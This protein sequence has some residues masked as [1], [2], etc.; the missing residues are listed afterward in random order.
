MRNSAFVFIFTLF[1]GL[2][3]KAEAFKVLEVRNNKIL[4]DLEGEVLERGDYLV[5]LSEAEFQ[6]RAIAIQIRPGQAI[7]KLQDGNF[8]LG[9][10][11][12][13]IK[14]DPSFRE[15]AIK[16]SLQVKMLNNGI[17][18]KQ[19]DGTFPTPNQETVSM[20]GS[21]LG[22]MAVLD[23][24]TEWFLLRGTLGLEPVEVTG[25]A[26]YNSC[27][28]KTS[29]DCNANINYIAA[30]AAI[31]YD[32]YRKN[33]IVLWAAAGSAIK[34]PM[35]KES[36]SLNEGA[37]GIA[38]SIL[39]STGADYLLGKSYFVPVGAEYHYSLNYSD[40]VPIISQFAMH[41]GIGME[42]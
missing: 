9:E 31:R 19:K 42:F 39:L 23:W 20:T 16:I 37:I 40:K 7:A 10:R 33:R 34:F 22:G 1:F 28:S 29:K 18:I 2:S 15:E 11:V 38:N 24:P 32:Y 25:R 13:R 4:V 6:G 8:T 26:K 30:S 12:R 5:T 41:V 21:S 36:T 27:S 35:N 14:S 17:S 3:Y